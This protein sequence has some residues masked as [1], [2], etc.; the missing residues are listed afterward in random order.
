MSLVLHLYCKNLNQ[1]FTKLTKY[2]MWVQP[3]VA[4]VLDDHQL[5]ADS[6]SA[7]LEKTFMFEEV[8]VESDTKKLI[9]Y[10]VE[11]SKKKI[12]LFLDYYL[13]GGQLGTDVLSDVRRLNKRVNIIVVSTVTNLGIIQTI[14]SYK[15]EGFISKISGFDIILDC[16]KHIEKGKTY[17]CPVIEKNIKS[18]TG[19]VVLFTK[20]QVEILKCFAQGLTVPQTSEKMHISLH[21][22]VTHRRR[23]MKKADCHTIIELLSYARR[24]KIILD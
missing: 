18:A 11:N 17:C 2:N 15:P 1:R 19:N 23:M 16:V 4:F 6:F 8:H 5:F 3:K 13:D 24:C 20:R 14:K 7:L 10:L 22:V 12:Y 9:Q 21:T